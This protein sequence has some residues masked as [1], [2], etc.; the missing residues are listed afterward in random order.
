LHFMGEGV[1]A[2]SYAQRNLENRSVS[3]VGLR[4]LS[5][6]RTFPRPRETLQLAEGFLRLGWRGFVDYLLR[7]RL[8]ERRRSERDYKNGQ[9]KTKVFHCSTLL[10][11]LGLRPK[12][13][14]PIN[15]ETRAIS[16]AVIVSYNTISHGKPFEGF[17]AA[18]GK[19]GDPSEW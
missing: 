17:F 18:E 15:A 9:H 10:K 7:V 12:R 6:Y 3:E 8:C 16:G 14:T 13:S 2:G 1:S 11:P 4:R 5:C 19:Q